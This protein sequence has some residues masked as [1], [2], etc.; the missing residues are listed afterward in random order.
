[1]NSSLF[2]RS[3]EDGDR[4]VYGNMTR[5]IKKLFSEKK[6]PIEYR[7]TIP[8]LESDSNIL[9]IPGFPYAY[10]VSPKLNQGLPKISIYY[11]KGLSQN[12]EI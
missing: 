12:E 3:K 8:I 4:Y 9:Y 1:M 2:A 7:A 5:S 6:L 11:M 10:L